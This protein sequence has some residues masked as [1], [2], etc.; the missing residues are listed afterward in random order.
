MNRRLL[1][2]PLATCALGVAATPPLKNMWH[3]DC[4]VVAHWCAPQWSDACRGVRP[5]D[6]YDLVVT[7]IVNNKNDNDKSTAVIEML[8][9]IPDSFAV[10][11]PTTSPPPLSSALTPPSPMPT[12]LP[13]LF[14]DTAVTW[15][16]NNDRVE[17]SFVL[18][19]SSQR[20]MVT[21]I[22][23]SDPKTEVHWEGT[24]ARVNNKLLTTSPSKTS[25]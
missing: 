15:K 7:D 19:R 3:L 25:R 24:C 9:T 13:A 20:L 6:E 8:P 17:A 1:A 16:F 11:T 5:S 22:T 2:I 10:P 4:P 14:G 18:L 23:K 12:K 21:T